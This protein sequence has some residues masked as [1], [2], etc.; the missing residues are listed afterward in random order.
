MENMSDADLLNAYRRI[1]GEPD[2]F[3]FGG[4]IQAAWE[5]AILTEMDRRGIKW[6]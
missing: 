6:R 1:G 4:E 2:W 3:D 5:D